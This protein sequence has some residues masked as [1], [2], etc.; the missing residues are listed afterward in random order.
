[1]SALLPVFQVKLSLLTS[2]LKYQHTKKESFFFLFFLQNHF[3]CF[4]YS[5]FCHNETVGNLNNQNVENNHMI[6][7]TCN[8]TWVRH[9]AQKDKLIP[10]IIIIT[11]ESRPLSRRP[12]WKR[13]FFIK[14]DKNVPSNTHLFSHFLTRPLINIT[15]P[16]F[17]KLVWQRK[18]NN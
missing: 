5:M 8:I 10:S 17:V 15:F 18:K 12:D 14:P 13:T 11:M 1:M 4:T 3:I 6:S 9:I 7:H 16:T 2:P